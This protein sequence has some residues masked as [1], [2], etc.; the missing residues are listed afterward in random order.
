MFLR[1]SKKTGISGLLRDGFFQRPWL[2]GAEIR[3]FVIHF[4]GGDGA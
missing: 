3:G 4:C 2:I 1:R